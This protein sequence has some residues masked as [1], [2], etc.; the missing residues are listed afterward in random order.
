LA[1]GYERTAAVK[2]RGDVHLKAKAEETSGHH[3]F[4]RLAAALESE[5]FMQRTV[6]YRGLE[7][8]VD[9]LSTSTDMLDVWF[10]ASKDLSGL[11]VWQR[12]ASAS[13]SAVARFPVAGPTLL[14]RSPARPLSM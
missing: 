2:N 9:W 6:E 4:T 12:S 13:R 1:A 5:V 3:G 10:F 14:R 11:L 8:H 7:I